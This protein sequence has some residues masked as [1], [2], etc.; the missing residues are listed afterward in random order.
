MGCRIA[1]LLVRIGQVS[2]IATHHQNLLGLTQHNSFYAPNRVVRAALFITVF[3][4]SRLTEAPPSCDV[5]V[6]IYAPTITM[7]WQEA[8]ENHTPAR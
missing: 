5:T 3:Q 7:A 6:S 4:G 8:T 1:D 2:A